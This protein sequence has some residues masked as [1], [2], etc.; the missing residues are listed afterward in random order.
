MFAVRERR[1]GAAGLVDVAFTDRHGGVSEPP[2]DSLDLRGKDPDRQTEFE[3]NLRSVA[4]AFDV[5]RSGDD[6]SG[7]RQRRDRRRLDPA[8]AASIGDALVTASPRSRCAVRVADCVPVVLADADEG[9]V[10]VAHAGR[11][12]VAAGVVSRDGR[13]D[14]RSWGRREST[15]G[16]DRT[17]AAAATRC[18]CEMRAEVAQVVPAA[19]ASRRGGRRRSISAPRSPRSSS[20]RGCNVTDVSIC[21]RESP[22]LYSHRRDGE[23]AGRFAGLVV[24]RGA[25]PCLTSSAGRELAA[26]LK[27]VR[28]EIAAAAAAAGRSADDV[29]LIVVTKTWPASDVRILADLGVTDVA[30]NRHPEAEDKARELADLGLTWHFVGQIQTNKA[31]RIAGYAD[32]VHS[33]D[34]VR[35]AQRLNAG[36]HHHD[37]VVDCLVQVSLDPSEASAGRGGVA[38]AEVGEVAAAIDTRRWAAA[39][40]RDGGR[41]ARRRRR[42]GVPH[43]GRGAAPTARWT[44]RT[45]RSIRRG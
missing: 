28:A 6:A 38:P 32:V 42:R 16:S 34:S 37:R 33:V 3:A 45:P 27:T 41:A 4:D 39:A 24:L 40:R 29:T 19:F 11:Q 8:T 12:G 21:T 43:P 10:G 1:R 14:A 22:D 31:N 36:A 7:A 23:R 35:L 2:F 5:D 20:K 18:R 9:V 26:R 15:P 25:R 44:S 13:G 17:C 30:E